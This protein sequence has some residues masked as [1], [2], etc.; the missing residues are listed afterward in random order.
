MVPGAA[1]P[2]AARARSWEIGSTSSSETL[3]RGAA[4][5]PAGP[6]EL[7]LDA[8]YATDEV[9]AP[10]VAGLGER[11]GPLVFQFPPQGERLRSNPERF[12]ARLE[13]FLGALPRGPWYAVELRDRELFGG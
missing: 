1:P 7:Y 6:N 5:R 13:R 11:A 9:I 8:A 3:D 4:G 2:R 12:A 10:Y